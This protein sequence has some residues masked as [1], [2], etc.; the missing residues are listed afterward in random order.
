MR[1]LCKIPFNEWQL[2]NTN[3]NIFWRKEKETLCSNFLREKK[4]EMCFM[5]LAADNA[6]KTLAFNKIANPFIGI[7]SGV[8]GSSCYNKFKNTQLPDWL[9]FFSGK[10]SGAI[11]S[12]YHCI[13]YFII[14]MAIAVRST[15]CT[16]RCSCRYG[17]CGC[18]YLRILKPSV[19]SNWITSRIKQRILV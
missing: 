17:C 9:A 10:R 6:T 3:V 4:R 13:C 18:W 1:K 7:L 11:V 12:F 16:W 15:C 8:I 2:R 19:D 14:C 5:H